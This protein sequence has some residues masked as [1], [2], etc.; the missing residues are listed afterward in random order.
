MKQ[1]RWFGLVLLLV[2]GCRAQS[3]GGSAGQVTETAVP[4]P[5]PVPTLDQ[6]SVALGAKVYSQ[7]CAACHGKNLEGEPDWKQQNPDGT[8]RAPPHDATGHTWHHPDTVL[9][10]AIRL[11]GARLPDN[12]G[13]TSRMPAFADVLTDEEMTAVLDYIKSTWPPDVRQMQWEV[14]IQSNN[15]P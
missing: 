14:T 3:R 10:E 12:I 9:L 1:W 15:M 7:Y 8:F 2:V 6:N 13:G 11:G 5:L 4:S